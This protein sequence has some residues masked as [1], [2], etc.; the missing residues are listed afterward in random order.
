[1]NGVDAIVIASFVSASLL[2]G[3]VLLLIRAWQ[4]GSVVAPNTTL[5]PEDMLRPHSRD[6]GSAQPQAWDSFDNYF[7]RLVESSGQPVEP[8]VVILV[9]LCFG[10]LCGGITWLYTE[11]ELASVGVLL[12]SLGAGFIGLSILGMQ[13]LNRAATQMPLVTDSLARG[14]RAG[15][16]LDQVFTNVAGKTPA[17]LGTALWQCSRQLQFGVPLAVA[18]EE[19]ERRFPLV[20]VRL[21]TTSLVM[22]RQTGG[23]L[24]AT[25]E[26]L[27]L[28][29][30][31]RLALRRQLRATTAAARMAAIIVAITSPLLFLYYLISERYGDVLLS[32]EGGT[33]CLTVA[34]VLEVAGIA[35]LLMLG[36]QEG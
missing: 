8:Q 14:L 35:W 26:R 11:H 3:G 16:S 10:S 24:S 21:L 32:T 27:S 30:R 29:M 18:V 9:L 4:L 19:L 22:Y 20:E 13:R 5:R 17:P 7:D 33:V 31:Q 36:R 25:L 2:V 12:A 28:M 6:R 15:E 34:A 23:D 1:M